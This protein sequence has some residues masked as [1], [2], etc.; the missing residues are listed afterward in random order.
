MMALSMALSDY[1][2]SNRGKEQLAVE[3]AADSMDSLV[4]T[5]VR[6]AGQDPTLARTSL[7]RAHASAETTS[8]PLGFD[9]PVIEPVNTWDAGVVEPRRVLSQAIETAHAAVEPLLTVD[10]VV[11]P[12]VDWSEYTPEAENR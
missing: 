4:R 9:L 12:E 6:N 2:S 8:A 5:L 3:A 10:T 11:H 7:R 1:V